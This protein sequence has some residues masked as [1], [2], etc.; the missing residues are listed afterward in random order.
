MGAVQ[1]LMLTFAAPANARSCA[2]AIGAQTV[3][4]E[5]LLV[6]ENPSGSAPLDH[7][8]LEHAAGLPVELVVLPQN[9]GPAGGYAAGIARLHGADTLWV[10]DDDVLP[11]PDCLARQLAVSAEHD[12]HALV[13]PSL[14]D[15][16]TGAE[17]S[18]WGWVGVLIPGAAVAA[19]GTP[20]PALF[21]GMEDQDYLID[22][23]GQ[24]GYPLVRADD[25]V[26]ELRRRT[27]DARPDWHF[28][29]L[30]R[31]LVYQHLYRRRHVRFDLRLKRLVAN[32]REVWQLEGAR[33]SPWK[34]AALM[35]RGVL[36]GALARLGRRVD[37]GSGARPS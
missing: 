19:V 8:E 26:A 11:R 17:C 35:A 6:V 29:Y 16:E 12:H 33:C 36:H 27:G 34:R 24:M 32:L 1:A 23:C 5:H 18:T 2:A 14:V 9:V 30:S 15:A 37:P 10:L 3:R 4:P 13:F 7:A 28:Y 20:D 21:Y 22:R 31:N 25:A